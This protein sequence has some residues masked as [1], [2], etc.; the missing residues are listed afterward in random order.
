MG[1]T[2][3]IGEVEITPLSVALVPI[4]LVRTIEPVEYRVEERNS[5]VLRFKLTNLSNQQ[6]LKPLARSLIS[7]AASPL[8]R[9][10]VVLPDG[11]KIEVYPLAV[12]SEWLIS[13]QEFS[14][15]KPGESVATLVASEPVRDDRLAEEMTWRVRLES[16]PLPD[17]HTRGSFQTERPVAVIASLTLKECRKSGRRYAQA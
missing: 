9:S 7:D 3:R 5:L 4:E 2:V 12:E 15:L 16:R 17:R 1:Q 11:G 13:G 6:S 10:F 8:D 14:I